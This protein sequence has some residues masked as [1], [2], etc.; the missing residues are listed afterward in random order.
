MKEHILFVSAHLPSKRIPEAGQ[1][2]AYNNLLE[3]SKQYR[4]H[5]ISFVNNLERQFVNKSELSFC[6]TVDYSIVNDIT[7]ILG[8]VIH[9]HL[10]IDSAARTFP[11]IGKLLAKQVTLYKPVL[12]HFEYTACAYYLPFVRTVPRVILSERDVTFQRIERK[13]DRGRGIGSVL[14]R[15]EA[16]R[17]RSWET[18]KLKCVSE[19]WVPSEKDRAIVCSVGVEETRVVVKGARIDPIF[20]RVD[21]SRIER[22]NVLFWGAMNRMENDDGILW[23]IVDIWPLI[24]LQLPEARLNVVGANP[25]RALLAKACDRIVV[26]GFVEDPIEYFERAQLFIA[27]LRYG[28]GVKVK[29]L[30][31]LTAGIPTVA[32]P[33]G[34]EGIDHCLLTVAHSSHDFAAR[35]CKAL[36]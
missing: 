33:V 10:P 19:V 12:V 15:L 28:A 24:L 17:Q 25:S 26:T 3:Y 34:A 20:G 1:R 27:P 32:T 4:V 35:V 18:R 9:P 29:V 14:L 22:G 8:M 31:A 21:R 13:A 36:M 5:L 6:D 30:E 23:F 7:R 2:N 16:R 11:C